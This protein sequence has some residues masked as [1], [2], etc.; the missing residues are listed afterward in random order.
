M[1][2]TNISTGQH[3]QQSG[4]NLDLA[5]SSDVKN[6]TLDGLTTASSKGNVRDTTQQSEDV[7]PPRY[8][9]RAH[10]P[11]LPLPTTGT[12]KP[13][14]ENGEVLDNSQAEEIKEDQDF[15]KEFYSILDEMP[16]SKEQR[17]KARFAYLNPN[18]PA[19]PD[20]K[21]AVNAARA[22]TTA[23]TGIPAPEADGKGF[24]LIYGKLHNKY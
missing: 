24:E 10:E 20:I 12:R 3:Q 16:L 18:V 4:W 11:T 6:T 23:Q 21:E 7:P 1:S 8:T 2:E 17:A 22:Q 14:G 9:R 13:K 5:G 19:D 15:T